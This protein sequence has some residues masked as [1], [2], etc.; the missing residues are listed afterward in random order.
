MPL[1]MACLVLPELSVLVILACTLLECVRSG[2]NTFKGTKWADYEL[3]ITISSH[4][5]F[6][7]V[8][9]IVQPHLARRASMGQQQPFASIACS[10][11][12]AK[13]GPTLLGLALDS[14]WLW[15]HQTLKH[16]TALHWEDNVQ[17]HSAK[18]W[19]DL[20]KAAWLLQSVLPC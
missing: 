3:P 5:T 15:M 14:H 19:S 9:Q 10:I 2:C 8:Q 18:S 16:L 11:P 1:C 17:A 13:A 7:I 4:S 20:N 12:T 6:I